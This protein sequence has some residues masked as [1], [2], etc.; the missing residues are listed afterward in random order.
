MRYGVWGMGM[1][2]G[3]WGIRYGVRGMGYGVWK[4]FNNLRINFQLN[5]NLHVFHEIIIIMFDMTK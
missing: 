2:Y 4:L 1:R 3:V 5:V